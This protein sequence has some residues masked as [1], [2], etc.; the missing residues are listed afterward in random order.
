M[1]WCPV[2]RSTRDPLRGH[3][4]VHLSLVI[5]SYS[6]RTTAHLFAACGWKFRTQRTLYMFVVWRR[7]RDHQCIL[8][9]VG[10]PATPSRFMIRLIKRRDQIAVGNPTVDEEFFLPFLNPL[11][12]LIG[13]A[14]RSNVGSAEWPDSCGFT[15]EKNDRFEWGG[16]LSAAV[17]RRFGEFRL[18]GGDLRAV[19]FSRNPCRCAAA[20]GGHDLETVLLSHERFN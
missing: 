8:F 4:K 10:I 16:R 18:I 13:R 7:P 12:F 1:H 9:A 5:A 14:Q 3:A 15:G 6:R 2:P 19:R 11:E 20:V 17:I